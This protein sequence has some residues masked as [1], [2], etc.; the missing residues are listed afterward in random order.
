[1]LLCSL[2]LEKR[3]QNVQRCLRGEQRTA[4]LEVLL[5]QSIWRF[6]DW[7]VAMGES[8]ER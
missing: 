6:R 4:F 8:V 7:G 3:Q 5:H 1:M 2:A